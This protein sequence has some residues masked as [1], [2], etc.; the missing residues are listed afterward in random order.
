MNAI[1]ALNT[2]RLIIATEA[3]WIQALVEDW[4]VAELYALDIAAD[5][6]AW[7]VGWVEWNVVLHYNTQGRTG[8]GVLPGGP[9]HVNVGYGSALLLLQNDDGEE[10]LIYQPTYWAIGHF[11]R[12]ARPGSKRV[13]T[14]GSAGIAVASADYEAVR[15]HIYSGS[16]GGVVPLVTNAFVSADGTT[17][18]V[19]VLNA[20]EQPVE[21]EL[22]D[23]AMG[24]GGTL[25]AV[26][27]TIPAHSIQTLTYSTA[28]A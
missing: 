2:S 4:Q 17:A 7:A 21:F 9:N 15:A 26:P 20:G 14:A 10:A 3:C 11:S 12:Y 5:I 18:S 13:S 25:A 8:R 28:T 16:K 23:T 19:V 6:N 24:S 27:V 1:H 22:R